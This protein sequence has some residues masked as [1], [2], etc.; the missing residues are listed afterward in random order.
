MK[1]NN[2]LIF[3]TPGITLHPLKQLY[4]LYLILNYGIDG[5]TGKVLYP[6]NALYFDSKAITII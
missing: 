5:L 6:V 3:Q 2:N 1:W 4:S